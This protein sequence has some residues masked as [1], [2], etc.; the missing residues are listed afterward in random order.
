MCCFSKGD[1]SWKG[2]LYE[3][4]FKSFGKET[5]RFFC[6][7][8]ETAKSLGNSKISGKQQ[9]LTSNEIPT[10]KSLRLFPQKEAHTGCLS[11]KRLPLKGSILLE[12]LIGPSF[13]EL[14]V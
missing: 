14:P 1:F 6:S 5:H 3:P 10:E 11:R 9:N 7:N 4:L 13:L 8:L 12:N 2:I